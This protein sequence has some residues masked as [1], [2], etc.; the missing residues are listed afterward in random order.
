[1]LHLVRFYF[2]VGVNGLNVCVKNLV[3]IKISEIGL[4]AESHN[5]ISDFKKLLAF[6]IYHKSYFELG[7]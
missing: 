2:N 3:E 5:V 4:V 7:A 6:S 1:M